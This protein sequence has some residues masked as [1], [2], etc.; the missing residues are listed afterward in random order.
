MEG[1]LSSRESHIRNGCNAYSSFEW[2]IRVICHFQA[3]VGVYILSATSLTA[4][5]LHS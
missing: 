5:R 3:N 2:I 1:R 4:M